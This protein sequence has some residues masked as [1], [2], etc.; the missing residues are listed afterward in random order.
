ELADLRALHA[1]QRLAPVGRAGRHL[2]ATDL[3]RRTRPRGVGGGAVSEPP[4]PSGS[5]GPADSPDAPRA[6]DTAG[7]PVIIAG[8][9]PVGLVAALLLARWGIPAVVLEAEDAP[10]G[11][12]SRSICVQRDVLDVYHRVGVADTLVA[13]GVTWHVGRTYHQGRELFSV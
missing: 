13:R 7:L 4:G 10:A 12:G 11:T 3:D 5:A 8:G 1:V 6:A 9:G 2:L